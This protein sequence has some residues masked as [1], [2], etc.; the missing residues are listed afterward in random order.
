MARFRLGKFL[1]LPVSVAQ[2]VAQR[3]EAFDNRVTTSEDAS[4]NIFRLPAGRKIECVG[5]EPVQFWEVK[6]IFVGYSTFIQDV[7]ADR[8]KKRSGC[9]YGTFRVFGSAFQRL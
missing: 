5:S 4:E 3:A 8:L 9:C 1:A 7:F 2:L 6:L